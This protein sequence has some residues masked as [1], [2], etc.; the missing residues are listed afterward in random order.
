ME[1]PYSVIIIGAGIAG[2]ACAKHLVE[3]SVDDFVILE[4]EGQLGG[5][6]QT[7]QLSTICTSERIPDDQTVELG[8]EL[9]QGDRLTN[10]LC[11]LA[12]EHD[13]LEHSEGELLPSLPLFLPFVSQL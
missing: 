6:C 13:L 8:A 4:A 9:L 11:Q 7:I 1:Q 3:N 12:H 10:P 5:R 2:L